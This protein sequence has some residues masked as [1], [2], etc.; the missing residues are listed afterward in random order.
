MPAMMPLTVEPKTMLASSIAHGRGKPSGET[1]DDAEHGAEYY[2]KQGFGHCSS[3]FVNLLISF[4]SSIKR[5]AR[6]L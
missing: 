4:Y 5:A 6:N 3:S 1:V 2:S